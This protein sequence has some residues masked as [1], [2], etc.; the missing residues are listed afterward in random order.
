MESGSKFG[1]RYSGK[2][3][4]LAFTYIFPVFCS[5]FNFVSFLNH[6]LERKPAQCNQQQGPQ[7]KARLEGPSGDFALYWQAVCR[8]CHTMPALG[9]GQK[10]ESR[11]CVAPWFFESVVHIVL[12][13]SR[14]G[15]PRFPSISVWGQRYATPRD[16]FQFG[17]SLLSAQQSAG[18]WSNGRGRCCKHGRH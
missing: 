5:T 12:S 17:L 1:I 4:I 14:P 3:T 8:F 11:G 18:E 16:R 6:R 2:V 15:R 9:H 7:T 13:E 10:T